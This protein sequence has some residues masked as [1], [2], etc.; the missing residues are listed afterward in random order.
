LVWVFRQA[1]LALPDRRKKG[2]PRGGRPR[3]GASRF[4]PPL[5]LT[6]VLDRIN[7]AAERL[8]E[9][10]QPEAAETK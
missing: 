6:V 1:Y 5:R 2:K 10:L 8:I 7:P 3:G 9:S 4:D